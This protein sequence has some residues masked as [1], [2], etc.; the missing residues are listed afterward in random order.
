[1]TELSLPAKAYLLAC[2]VI[3]DS[4]RDRR[5]ASLLIRGAA[6]TDLVLRGRAT[7]T[8]GRVTLSG[9]GPTGD[10]VLDELLAE[11]AGERPR[12]W[13]WWVRKDARGTL[14]ALESQLDAAG[15][16]ELRTGRILGLFP[17]RRPT[18]RDPA[19]VD[20]LRARVDQA[21][22][23]PSPVSEV[24]A[25]DAALTALA[26]AVELRQVI[27]GRDRRRYKERIEGLAERGG[28]AVPA[29][30]KLFRELRAVRASAAA[31][32]GGS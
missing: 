8:D 32:S 12:K 23:G 17:S 9:A 7:D 6:M 15:V 24:D 29:L 19:V 13:K 5:R 1:M 27:P 18:V 11:I 2:D 16:L 31:S 25:G 28:D 21:L 20:R 10:L 26:A 22:R 3:H 14:E 30:R 4:L